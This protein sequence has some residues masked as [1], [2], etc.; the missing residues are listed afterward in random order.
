[1]LVTGSR[2]PRA[3]IEGPAP[4]TVVTAEDIR[5][6]GL[7]TVYDVVRSLTQSTGSVQTQRFQGFTPGAQ[8]STCAGSGRATRSCCSMAGAWRTFR[9]RTTAKATLLTLPIFIR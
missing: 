5:A 6:K 7:A 2:V 9:S 8:R 4:V 1:M 3:T